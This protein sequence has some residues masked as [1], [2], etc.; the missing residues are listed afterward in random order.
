M[1]LFACVTMDM[2]L[3]LMEKLV[4]VCQTCTLHFPHNSE[5]SFDL[6]QML[7]SVKLAVSMM[8]QPVQIWWAVSTARV[9]LDSPK[10]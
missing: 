5:C 3:N 1:G 4:Q 6:I 10:I 2:S 8:L 9:M 7:M